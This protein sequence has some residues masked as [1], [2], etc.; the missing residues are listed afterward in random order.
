MMHTNVDLL[1]QFINFLIRK[2]SGGTVKNEIISNN[3]LPEELDKLIIN[4][5]EKKMHS[6]IIQIIFGMQIWKICN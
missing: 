2:T 6:H 1:Q 4:K 5:I 3:K